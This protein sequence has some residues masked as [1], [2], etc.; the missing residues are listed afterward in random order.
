MR[1]QKLSDGAIRLSQLNPWE[2]QTF[3][4]L[5]ILADFSDHEAAERRMLPTPAVESDLTPD[6]GMDWVEYVMPELRD[7]FARNL[8]T[9]M[10]DLENLKTHFPGDPEPDEADRSGHSASILDDDADPWGWDDDDDESRS[11]SS[12]GTGKKES[13]PP[14]QKAGPA[15]SQSGPPQE[16]NYSVDIPS[17]HAELWFRAMNQARLV[18]SAK[19]GI[20]SE[21]IPDLATLLTSGKLEYWFQYE[22]FVSLQ[23]WLV[24][25]VLDTN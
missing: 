17:E 15:R 4:S 14:P 3:R 9:V 8:S 23:G 22:L 1:L 21:H 25:A 16:L 7:S 13:G 18:L 6:M 10:E 2:V 19:H 24:D 12:S 11:P 5:P 20:D